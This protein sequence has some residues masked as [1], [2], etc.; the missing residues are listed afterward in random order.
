VRANRPGIPPAHRIVH[1]LGDRGRCDGGTAQLDPQV[2]AGRRAVPAGW[3]DDEG[4]LADRDLASGQT[5]SDCFG[6]ED[7]RPSEEKLGDEW[8]GDR[9]EDVGTGHRLAGKSAGCADRCQLSPVCDDTGW[10]RQG[11]TLD[12]TRRQPADA[13]GVWMG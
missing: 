7:D 3:V 9:R 12:V 1:Q 8:V 6:I 13:P 5:R 10:L 2:A 4:S 11:K